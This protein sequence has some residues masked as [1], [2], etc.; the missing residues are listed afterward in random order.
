[1]CPPSLRF[2]LRRQKFSIISRGIRRRKTPSTA[3]FIGGCSTPVSSDGR[4]KL[5]RPLCNS[6]NKVFSKKSVLRTGKHFTTSRRVISPRC[7]NSQNQALHLQKMSNQD[8]RGR[9]CMPATLTYAGGYIEESPTESAP[10]TVLCPRR[11]WTPLGDSP[12]LGLAAFRAT[13]QQI[14]LEPNSQ[15]PIYANTN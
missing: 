1:M 11:K 10:L 7:G 2:H 8:L 12:P 13:S 9:T 4:R 14:S 15:S 5:R 3:S 6:S